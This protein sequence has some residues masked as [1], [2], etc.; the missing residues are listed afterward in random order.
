ME[1]WELQWAMMDLNLIEANRIDIE[2]EEAEKREREEL[3]ARIKAKYET[4]LLG[5][6][7]QAGP[8]G[9]HVG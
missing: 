7:D 1:I 6:K 3:I 5:N 4:A 8:T 2:N 9:V